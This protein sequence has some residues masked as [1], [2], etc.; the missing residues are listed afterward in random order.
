MKDKAS[1]KAAP[2]KDEK[3]ATKEAPVKAA[4]PAT[5][6]VTSAAGPVIATKD[7]K[8][9]TA[10][11]LT[12][13]QHQPS[14]T[15]TTAPDLKA[16]NIVSSSTGAGKLVDG[17]AVKQQIQDNTVTGVFALKAKLAESNKAQ[18][19]EVI[20]TLNKGAQDTLLKALA[21]AE[22][23]AKAQDTANTSISKINQ[24]LKDLGDVKTKISKDE[25]SLNKLKT[26]LAAAISKANAQMKLDQTKIDADTKAIPT[27]I[28]AIFKSTGS[29]AIPDAVEK[30]APKFE[31]APYQA[32][33]SMMHDANA[34]HELTSAPHYDF[35]TH[36]TH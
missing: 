16:T 7:L 8:A 10:P 18:K 35:S 31:S 13:P 9:T 26:D 19:K 2:K 23:I 15:T 24:A 14:G 22:T 36:F 5:D 27:K 11:D 25:A 32:H 20:D 17:H 29:D 34:V 30:V 28:D 1:A 6:K 3:I 4:V 21:Q 12:Q 33:I